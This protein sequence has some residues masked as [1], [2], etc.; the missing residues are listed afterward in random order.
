MQEE[1]LKEKQDQI[2]LLQSDL[3]QQQQDKDDLNKF[4]KDEITQ[5]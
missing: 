5:V 3:H 4:V 1:F 2:N